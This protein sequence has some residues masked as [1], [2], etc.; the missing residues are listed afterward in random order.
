VHATC[1]VHPNLLYLSIIRMKFDP[2][3]VDC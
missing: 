1:P 3:T 2:H